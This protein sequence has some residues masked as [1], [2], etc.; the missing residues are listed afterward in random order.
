MS[1]DHVIESRYGRSVTAEAAS[2]RPWLVLVTGEPG[3]GKST[4][5]GHLADA[6]RIPYLSR[7]DVRWGLYATAGVWTNDVRVVPERDDAVEAFLQLIE[8]AAAL[9]ISAVLEIIVF[10]DRPETLARL[11]AIADC[12]VV[13]ATATDA[14]DRAD[15]RDQADPLLNRRPVLDALGH[16]SVESYVAGAGRNAVRAGMTTDFDLPTL[17]V[18]TDDG[19]EP[20]LDQVVEWVIERTSDGRAGGR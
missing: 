5:G 9:G 1:H 3:A 4:L 6:L 12:L 18:R 20:P 19:C 17:T 15:R 10:R 7:D 14:P 13:I 11:R 16:P 8:K 2:R